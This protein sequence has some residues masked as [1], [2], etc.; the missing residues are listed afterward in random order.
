LCVLGSNPC[1]QGE[2]DGHQ[3]KVPCRQGTADAAHPK[4]LAGKQLTGAR[5]FFIVAGSALS[6]LAPFPAD[7]GLHLG[8]DG[9]A[10]FLAG[11]EGWLSDNGSSLPA[12][13]PGRPRS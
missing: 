6:A 1:R 13:P 10:N 7:A 11:K 8:W 12:R 5:G 4:L 2:M 3:A 9:P